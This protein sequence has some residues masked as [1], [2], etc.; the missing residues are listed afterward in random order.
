MLLKVIF[1]NWREPYEIEAP[2]EKIDEEVR[3][4]LESDRESIESIDTSGSPAVRGFEHL[5]HGQPLSVTFTN[6]WL[7]NEEIEAYILKIKKRNPNK[8]QEIISLEFSIDETNEDFV[9]CVI[10]WKRIPFDRIRRITGYLVGSTDRW[11]GA[12]KAELDDR[13]SHNT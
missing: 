4:L 10:Q 3:K 12:K 2:K 5:N 13:K 7:T 8:R 1:N 6:G 11:N 9:D